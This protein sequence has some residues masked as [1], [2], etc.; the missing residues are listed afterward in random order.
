MKIAWI[1]C[2][3]GGLD[4]REHDV[5][6]LAGL[7]EVDGLE[8]EAFNIFLRP[9]A[10]RVTAEALAVTGRTMEEVMAYPSRRDGYHQLLEVLGRHI[11]KYNRSDKAT[12]A[13]QNARFDMEFVRALFLEQGDKYFGSWFKPHPADLI[14]LVVAAQLRGHL[15]QLPDLKLLTVCQHLG[16]HL[17]AHDALNDIRATR[18]AFLKL[19]EL[20]AVPAGAAL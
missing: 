19:S 3:T 8:R 11:E 1:D 6:Q 16:I 5:V 7:I 14:S 10:G 18:A 2:E 15:R 4:A 13:G 17:E 12:W 9:R 20:I